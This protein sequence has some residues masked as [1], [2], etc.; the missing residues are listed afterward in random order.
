MQKTYHLHGAGKIRHMIL[1]G[2]GG[3]TI[4]RV[5]TDVKTENRSIARAEKE[6]QY[7]GVLHQDLASRNVL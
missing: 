6:I 4:D 2:W 5:E 1:M 7:L 3:D